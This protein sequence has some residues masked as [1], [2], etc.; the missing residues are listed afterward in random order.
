MRVQVEGILRPKEKDTSTIA[1]RPRE[2][3]PRPASLR[4]A[5]L[6]ACPARVRDL[7]AERSRLARRC[8]T[9][10]S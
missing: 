6:P 8:T 3:T 7:G 9:L 2:P 5:C 10:R 4:A 1:A